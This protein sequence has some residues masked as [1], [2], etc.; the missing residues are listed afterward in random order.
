MYRDIWL[1][2]ITDIQQDAVLFSQAYKHSFDRNVHLRSD[3]MSDIQEN[4]TVLRIQ[5]PQKLSNQKFINGS[6]GFVSSIRISADY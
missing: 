1:P 2:E 4:R 6:S 3:Q 5:T